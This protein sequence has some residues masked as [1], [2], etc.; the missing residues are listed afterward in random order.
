MAKKLNKKQSKSHQLAKARGQHNARPLL[1]EAL[2]ML[3]RGNSDRALKLAA[4]ALDLAATDAEHEAAQQL[5]AET[6]F[7]AAMEGPP[8]QRLARLE[9]ALTLTPSDPRLLI[10]QGVA[11]WQAGNLSAAAAAL[12]QA[13]ELAPAHPGLAYLRQLARLAQGESWQAEGLTEAEAN[14]LRTVQALIEQQA[15]LPTPAPTLAPQPGVWQALHQL[16]QGD[17]TTAAAPLKA[18]ADHA[19]APDVKRLLRYYQGIAAIRL[20]NGTAAQTAWQQAQ[21]L[22]SPTP[23]LAENL[24]LRLRDQATE[25]AAQKKWAAI[26]ALTRQT[27]DQLSD[28]ILADTIG[29]AHFHLGYE[30]AQAEQWG[31]AAQHWRQ[32][33]AWA[34]NRQIAQNLALAEEA[35]GN[36]EAA[37]QAWR[38]MARRRPRS[39][40]HPDYLDDNQVAG[41][42]RHAAECYRETGNIPEAIT[43]LKTAIKYAKQ[44]A[45]LRL[46]LAD[47]LLANEQVD[48]SLNELGRI[49]EIAP[50]HVGALMRLGTLMLDKW[51]EDS[52]PIWRRVLALEPTNLEARAGLS[53]AYTRV[54]QV[55]WHP[56][57]GGKGEKALIEE[58]LQEVGDYAPFLVELGLFYQHE[59]SEHDLS[60]AYLLRAAALDP[61]DPA[62]LSIILHELLH[63]GQSGDVEQ[64][65]EMARALPRLLPVF[66]FT[67]VEQALG[68]EVGEEWRTRFLDEAVALAEQPHVAESKAA[69]LIK[70]YEVSDNAEDRTLVAHV[71]QRIRAEIPESGGVEFIE[72]LRALDADNLRAAKQHFNK[73][74]RQARRAKDSTALAFIEEMATLTLHGPPGP[75]SPAMLARLMELFPDGPPSLEQLERLPDDFFD[76]LYF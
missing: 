20:E 16:A 12:E 70:A 48:A 32:A 15:T 10:Q 72:A 54:I 60:R 25:L 11:L 61:T 49:V 37:A 27:P 71:E 39:R 50:N 44:D 22:A 35:V 19:T 47:A 46:D 17:S 29:L 34:G 57:G 41:I 36:W 74:K 58:A 5:L 28:R 33:E 9:Q 1:E 13:A 75:L 4:E 30:A 40:N 45:D 68:C 53:Q 66:W 55:P 6:H 63:V 42:W 59:R 3:R 21:G 51:G 26:P 76:D 14:T 7:R 52:R 38:E 8:A 2:R 64:L 62:T 65:V 43:C 67:Q 69:L 56:M 23:W 18:A 24:S 73:A 31:R